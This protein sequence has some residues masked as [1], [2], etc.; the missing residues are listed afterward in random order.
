MNCP[1]N[2]SAFVFW[3]LFVSKWKWSMQNHI[4]AVHWWRNLMHH[5]TLIFVRVKGLHLFDTKSH[6]NRTVIKYWIK[7]NAFNFSMYRPQPCFLM[8]CD[9]K[10]F[11]IPAKSEFVVIVR[12]RQMLGTQ[13]KRNRTGIYYKISSPAMPMIFLELNRRIFKAELQHLE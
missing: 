13:S 5:T 9:G 11:C 2:I 12:A 8:L 1:R 4:W 10:H 6:Y 3:W 7:Q